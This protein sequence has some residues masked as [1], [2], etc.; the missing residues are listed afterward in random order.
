MSSNPI[1]AGVAVVVATA[2]LAFPVSSAAQEKKPATPAPKEVA[3]QSVAIAKGTRM[4]APQGFSVVLVLGEMQGGGATEGVPAAA[5]KALADMKDFL[6][7]KGYR[8]LDTQ[9]MLCCGSSPTLMRLR[10]SDEQ[11]YELEL[12]PPRAA[13]EGKW[14]VRFALREPLAGVAVA[15]VPPNARQA[16]ELTSQRRELE[17]RLRTLRERLSE[18]HPDIQATRAQIAELEGRVQ[19]AAL[20]ERAKAEQREMAARTLS[21][22]SHGR[23]II[24]TSFAMDIGETVVVGTS[25]LKGDKA[26]IAL[27]TAVPAKTNNSR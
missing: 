18:N 11:D 9:W 12:S 1:A 5:R 27:L 16:A 6:P 10:G 22:R 4:A 3:S 26:L 7:Y 2:A 14:Y 24:D 21:L 20:E 19:A 25:R 8:L 13:P 15:E 23:A 17:N